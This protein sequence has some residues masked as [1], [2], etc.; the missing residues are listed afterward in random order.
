MKG[1]ALPMGISISEISSKSNFKTTSN[2]MREL[3]LKECELIDGGAEINWGEVYTSA[4][5]SGIGSGIG[6]AI[7]GGI[8]GSFGGGIG[9]V[10]GAL[11]GG[12]A[13]FIGG[14][15]GGG[16]TSIL[17]QSFFKH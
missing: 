7:G 8:V 4:L 11:Y 12:A 17:H 14:A 1:L 6:G 3:T 15:I 13:G 16:L 10:P 2:E 5:A 9:A